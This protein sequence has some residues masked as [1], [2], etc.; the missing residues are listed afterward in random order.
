[1]NGQLLSSLVGVVS[2]VVLNETELSS[3]SDLGAS[4]RKSKISAEKRSRKQPKV[5]KSQIVS[6]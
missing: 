3:L 6:R 5:P 4:G 2:E 1:M